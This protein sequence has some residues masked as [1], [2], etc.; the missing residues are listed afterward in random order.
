MV[1]VVGVTPTSVDC[2]V[3]PAHAF[4]A[5]VAPVLVAAE[6]VAAA[7]EL[8]CVSV[9]VDCAAAP[10]WFPAE[11]AAVTSDV[12]TAA[13]RRSRFFRIAGGLLEIAVIH[14][15]LGRWLSPCRITRNQPSPVG[16]ESCSLFDPDVSMVLRHDL[17]VRTADFVHAESSD[18]PGYC[19][20]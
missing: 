1:M 17:T 19:R 9:G 10:P 3:T 2:S 4:D 7:A 13:T 6:L 15:H 11:Q 5:A 18:R 16:L 14:R 20:R 12:V 8:D